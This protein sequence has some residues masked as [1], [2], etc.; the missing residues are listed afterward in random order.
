M[1]EIKRWLDAHGHSQ[2]WLADRLGVS[3]QQVS[4]WVAGRHRPDDL[5]A[6]AI[7]RLTGGEVTAMELRLPGVSDPL[8][9]C[10]EQARRGVAPAVAS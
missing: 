8:L 5:Y 4:T 9:T 6:F 2:K 10:L 3:Q 7:E 1:S